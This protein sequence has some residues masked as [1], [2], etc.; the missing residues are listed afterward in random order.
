[1]PEAVTT[2]AAQ[3]AAVV[4]ELAHLT[5]PAITPLDVS[6]LRTVTGALAELAAG[7][8]QTLAQLASY[9]NA[10]DSLAVTGGQFTGD[11]QTAVDHAR[12]CLQHAGTGAAHLTA[13]LDAAHQTLGDLAETTETRS[14]GSI[15]NRR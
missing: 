13:A 9:L 1:M 2:L 6:D 3:A 5:R 15:F 14:V 8:P 12:T 11:P 7:M 10:A 4:H